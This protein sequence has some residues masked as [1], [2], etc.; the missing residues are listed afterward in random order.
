MRLLLGA[1]GHDVT[2]EEMQHL[3]QVRAVR[4]MRDNGQFAVATLLRDTGDGFTGPERHDAGPLVLQSLVPSRMLRRMKRGKWQRSIEMMTCSDL[5][6]ALVAGFELG[7]VQLR[8]VLPLLGG[9]L[10]AALENLPNGEPLRLSMLAE[11]HSSQMN[12]NVNFGPDG[13]RQLAAMVS[14][15]DEDLAETLGLLVELTQDV[16]LLTMG[17]PEGPQWPPL[18][19]DV[20][21]MTVMPTSL[22]RA[23]AELIEQGHAQAH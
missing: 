6:P 2:K 21:V 13:A 20:L 10:R 7:D 9:E 18:S 22:V 17:H 16:A 15:D 11:D 23:T 1:K 4:R 14:D 3:A 12:L 5:C 19:P 8:L